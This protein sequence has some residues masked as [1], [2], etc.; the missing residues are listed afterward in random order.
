MAWCDLSN[1]DRLAAQEDAPLLAAGGSTPTAPRAGR[2]AL[3]TRILGALTHAVS[4]PSANQRQARQAIALCHALLSERGEVSGLRLAAEVLAAYQSF[5]TTTL[6]VFFDLL[7]EEFSPNPDDVTRAI[8]AY[9]QAPSQEHLVRLRTLLDGPRQELFRRCNIAPGGTGVLVQMRHQLLATLADHPQRAGIDADLLH[10]FRSWFNRG[11][12]ILQRIDWRTSALVLERLIRYE[13]VHQI[14]GWS[15]L[16]RRLATD[17]RCYA[18]VHPALPD[19]P[20][21]FIEVALTRG[22]VTKVQPLLDPNSPVV[23]TA[24]ANC[25]T[26]YSITN[27][28]EGLRGVSFGHSLIKQAVEDLGRELPGL[29]TFATLSPIPGFRRWLETSSDPRINDY[30]SPQLTMLLARLDKCDPE[31]LQV[32]PQHLRDD[33]TRLCAHYLLRAKQGTAP[34]DPVARFHLANGARLQ[35]INWLADVSGNGLHQSVGLMANY[36]YRIRDTER[37]HEAYAKDYRVIASHELERLV[38]GPRFVP[39]RGG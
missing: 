8:E 1:S 11:F 18:F 16:R 27:C 19:E 21:I 24:A 32:I 23:D 37:N 29:R 34:L 7:V 25:A 35:Q 26:F 13:A 9:R 39:I 15:D 28:Q 38:K 14:Q 5:D 31:A 30:R 20:L 4:P 10:L 6:D 3:F 17:R 12:L 33:L 2:R 36:V 22:L